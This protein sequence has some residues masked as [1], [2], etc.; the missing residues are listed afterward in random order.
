MQMVKNVS[1]VILAAGLGTR[2]RSDKAKVL[3]AIN[4]TP[5]ILFVVETAV[6]VVKADCVVVVIGHQAETVRRLVSAHYPVSFALQAEQRGTGHAVRC[7]MK[8]LSKDTEHVIILCGDVPLLKPK[9]VEDLL[10][11]HCR[12]G[13]DLTVLAIEVADPKGYGRILTDGQGRLLEI[14]EDADA[15]DAQRAI[16]F[17]NSGIYC[18]AKEFLD[19]SL[20][21]LRPANIQ[22]EYYLTDIAS[23]ARVNGRQVGF[24]AGSD[25]HEVA[26]VNTV[27]QL[28]AVA[29]AVM[30]GKGETA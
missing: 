25:P 26:G 22:K 6:N 11:C 28:D 20:G 14:I 9:T 1:I 8:A 17:V 7:A 12:C 19:F 2:M 15:S 23:V 21:R 16:H 3:H 27:A 18:A 4:G 30:A 5:M 10:D 13:N 29:A 24:M